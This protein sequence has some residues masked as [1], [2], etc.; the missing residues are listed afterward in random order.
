MQREDWTPAVL[1]TAMIS[2]V[3]AGVVWVLAPGPFGAEDSGATRP[4]RQPPT[5]VI[6]WTGEL[7]P[8]VKGVL[9]PIWGDPGPDGE[10]DR[11]LNEGLGLSA[12]QPAPRWYRLLVFN[13]GTD[14]WE[15]GLGDGALTIGA[16]EG[17]PSAPLRNLGHWVAAGLAH[18]DPGLTFTLRTQGTLEERLHLPAGMSA[19]LV[20]PFQGRIGLENAVAVSTSEGRQLTRR[21]MERQRYRRLLEGAD[22]DAL[23]DL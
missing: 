18:P 11:E 4:R 12:P 6:V 23:R 3:T 19:Q 1:V 16:P 5:E 21:P 2:L 14:A 13:L 10:H 8:G 7:S 17:E 9:G 20:L 22:E 15:L